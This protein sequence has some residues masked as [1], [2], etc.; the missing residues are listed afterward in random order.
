MK[1]QINDSVIA[2]DKSTISNATIKSNQTSNNN[3]AS[4][5]TTISNSVVAKDESQITDASIDITKEKRKSF[6]SGFI[7]GIMMSVI[8]SAMW[9]IIETYLL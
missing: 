4:E 5:S 1:T 9:Y 8:A 6:W 3:E 7:G 2:T